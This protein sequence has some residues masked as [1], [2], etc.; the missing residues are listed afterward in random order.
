MSKYQYIFFYS[1]IIIALLCFS[2]LKILA[3]F[4]SIIL[5]F[6]FL[7]FSNDKLYVIK[8]VLIVFT[9]F[10]IFLLVGLL[11]YNNFII[12]NYILAFITYSTI[13]PIFFLDSRKLASTHLLKKILIFCSKLFFLE[14]V[15][16]IIQAIYGFIQTGTFGSDNGDYVEGTIHPQLYAERTF[17]NPM[18]SVNMILIGVCLLILIYVFKEKGKIRLFV[19]LFSIILASVVHSVLLFTI[20]V[21][22]AFIFIKPNFRYQETSNQNKQVSRKYILLLI[23]FGIFSA[24]YFIGN[25]ISQLNSII[26]NMILGNYPKAIVTENAVI[27]IPQEEPISPIIG[28]GPGQFSSRASLIGSGLYL[29]GIENPRSAPLL[30]NKINPIADEYVI[31]LLELEKNLNLP[32]FGSTQ[33]PYYSL[34]SVYSEMGIIGI[35]ALLLFLFKVLKKVKINSKDNDIKRL[36]SFIF[37][38]GTIFII[39]LGIQENYYEIPQAILIGV[40]LLKVIYSVIIYEPAIETG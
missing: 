13:Y 10:I 19:G 25:N 21:I 33:Q 18:F 5:I 20:S 35:L 31:S 32:V 39:S 14:A 29:G 12:Q 17:S 34:L 24:S 23:L 36:F 1:F 3:S 22:V 30:K 15:W 7:L 4:S 40:L 6:A 27:N 16:G 38:A 2:P 28:I 9:V 37:F 26:S 11:I 8:G